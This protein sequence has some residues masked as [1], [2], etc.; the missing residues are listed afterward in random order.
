M[1]TDKYIHTTKN[2]GYKYDKN[3]QVSVLIYICRGMF[4]NEDFTNEEVFACLLHE[5][6]HSFVVRGSNMGFIIS[7][8]NYMTLMNIILGAIARAVDP[9]QALQA[10]S[11]A[12]TSLAYSTKTGKHIIASIKNTIRKSKILHGMDKFGKEFTSVVNTI[13]EARYYVTQRPTHLILSIPLKLAAK[14]INP[15]W[16]L[17]GGHPFRP[18]EYL[19]DDFAVI[20]GFGAPLESALKKMDEWEY[21][22]KYK[23]RSKIPVIKNLNKFIDE[24][25]KE[26]SYS[27][28]MHPTADKRAYQ[29]RKTLIRELDQ[30]KDLDPRIKAQLKEQI[31]EICKN[32]E[33]IQAHNEVISNNKDQAVIIMREILKETGGELDAD[34]IEAS[35]LDRDEMD[36]DFLNRLYKD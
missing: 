18:I 13:I 14:I 16:K 2:G 36:Q 15:L 32:A 19:S 10:M 30:N 26:F 28:D 31:L 22:N 20:Y 24:A 35:L 4:N 11:Q 23:L 29:I 9:K 6:G 27:I 25:L 33:D 3:A 7:L 21:S 12:A 5:I 8:Y 1:N 34:T 17:I